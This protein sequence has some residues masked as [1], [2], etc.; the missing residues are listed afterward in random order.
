M[1]KSLKTSVNFKGDLRRRLE[2]YCHVNDLQTAQAVKMFVIQGLKKHAKCPHMDTSSRTHE[3]EE[4]LSLDKSKDAKSDSHV[5]FKG[6]IKHIKFCEIPEALAKQ[7]KDK[8]ESIRESKMT[9]E[10]MAESY[11]NYLADCKKTDT[12]H[13]HPQGWIAGHGWQRKNTTEETYE[14]SGNYDF[15]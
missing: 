8:W 15:M 1:S 3:V 11:N 7:I 12:K 2:W 13:K 4:N 5:F 9:A 6:F 10:E 14:P